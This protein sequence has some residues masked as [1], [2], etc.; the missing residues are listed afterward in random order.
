MPHAPLLPAF[1]L[2][3]PF[4]AQEVKLNGPLAREP[5]EEV[6]H[7]IGTSRA[8]DLHVHAV[9]KEGGN[10]LTRLW[11]VASDGKQE[12][13]LLAESGPRAFAGGLVDV[14][15]LGD[16]LLYVDHEAGRE[17]VLLPIDGSAPPRSLS[18]GAVFLFDACASSPLVVYD[19]FEDGVSRSSAARAT[20]ARRWRSLASSE[21]SPT[22][23]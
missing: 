14:R 21:G 1:G 12:R 19:S 2:L 15:L 3:L 10:D 17:L 7:W 11:S 22:S 4:A 8:G 23:C 18:E 9:R 16:E 20:V 6:I 5:L 13:I